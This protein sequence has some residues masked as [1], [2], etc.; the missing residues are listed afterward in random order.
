MEQARKL[1]SV[2][3]V[4]LTCPQLPLEERVRKFYAT[5]GPCVLWNSGCWVPSCH[6]SQMLCAQESRWLRRLLREPKGDDEEWVKWL[7]RTKKKAHRVRVGL[8]LPSIWHTALMGIH[9]W[10]GHLMRRGQSHPGHDLVTWRGACWWEDTKTAAQAGLLT[11]WRHPSTN[12]ARGFEAALVE[13]YGPV[14]FTFAFADRDEWRARSW[15][16]VAWANDKWGG[17]QWRGCRLRLRFARP[18][19]PWGD[20]E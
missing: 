14:W 8:R 19:A 4:A 5:L 15:H 3:T 16:F 20:L 17:P 10:A 12:W 9:G 1:F 2:L 6:V 11:D 7:R 18:H 13:W